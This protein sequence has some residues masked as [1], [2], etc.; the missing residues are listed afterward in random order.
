[1]PVYFGS[2]ALQSILLWL[3]PLKF[4]ACLR[5]LTERWDFEDE[6]EKNWMNNQW[7]AIIRRVNNGGKRV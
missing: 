6:R 3:R 5:A 4:Y 1:M 7:M 2:T